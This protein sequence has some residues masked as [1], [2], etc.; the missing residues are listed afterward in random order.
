M[1][2]STTGIRAATSAP[3]ASS[4]IASVIGSDVYSARLKSFVTVLPTTWFAL[5]IPNSSMR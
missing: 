3:N 4:R 5:A 2:P 1:N